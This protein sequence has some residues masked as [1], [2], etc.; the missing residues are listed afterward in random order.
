MTAD[1]AALDMDAVDATDAECARRAES[2]RVSLLTT[3]SC[4]FSSAKC[5]SAGVIG[6]GCRI[7]MPDE[8]TVV[9]Y[10]FALG[11]R[12][13]NPMLLCPCWCPGGRIVPPGDARGRGGGLIGY[14]CDARREADEEGGCDVVPALG[15]VVEGLLVACTRGDSGTELR[16]G[17]MVDVLARESRKREE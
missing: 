16:S 17:A 14:I 13:G 3:A 2:S 11:L 10:P 12:G 6:R 9:M 5:I 1:S 7:G 4:S 15:C 8:S